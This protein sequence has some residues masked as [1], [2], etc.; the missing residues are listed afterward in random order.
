MFRT[1]IHA[2]H[3][4]VLALLLVG[5]S[6]VMAR[7]QTCVPDTTPDWIASV[8]MASSSAQVRP[9]DCATVEQTPPDFSWPDLSADAQYQVTLT[10][11]DGHSKTLA[12]PQNWINWDEILPAGAY[13]WQVQATNASGTQTSRVRRFVV[14]AAA[15]PFL[16]PDWTV[17]FD[18][19]A[20][21]PH[22]RSLP[23]A[24]TWQTMINQRQAEFGLLVSRVDSKLADPVQAEPTSAVRAAITAQTH[25]EC[26]RML[27]AALAWIVTGRE[28]HWND[29][30][31]RALNLAA[32][33]P[34]GTT[35]YANADEAAR[36]VAWTLALAYDSLHARLDANQKSLL[37]AP[38]L[39]R[40]SDMYGD[41]IGTR[42]RVAV[43][44]YDSHGNHTLTFLA[45]IT[46]LL[47]GDLPEAY[48][49]LRDTLPLALSWI[50]PWGGED[51]GFGNG[52]A[53]AQWITGDFL[54]PWSILRWTLGI[55]VAQ[56][57]WVRNYARY[58]AYF[59]P[60]G[61]PVGAFGD[62]AELDLRETWGSIGRA[63][64]LFAPGPLARWYA[65]Q[66][67]DGDPTR[68][69]VLLAPPDVPGP[70]TFPEGTPD[71]ALLSS[72]G[73][74]AM[75]SSLAD[76][77]RI[78]IYFKSSLYGSYN[79][80]HADQ[81]SFV[82]NAGGR[83]LAID[84]GHY[85]DYDTPHWRQWY[86]Q[87]RAHNAVTYDGGQGQAVF[88]ETGL[89]GQGVITDYRQ[90]P[91]YDIV[92]GDATLA[93]GGALKEARRSLVYLRPNLAVVYDRLASD[94]PRR[95]EWNIHALN[96]MTVASERRIS[97]HNDPQSLCVDMLAGPAV[98]FAQTDLFTADPLNGKPRQ[99]HGSFQSVEPLASA[100]FV[101][102]LNVGC[103]P[104]AAGAS[105]ANGVWSVTV[106][107]RLVSIA[108]D[109]SISVGASDTTPP[110]VS[111]TSP[112]PGAVVS[113]TIP[114]TA[115]ASDNVGVVGVQF[116]YDGI[117][118]D[119]EDA[120]VPYSAT[121]YTNNVPNGSYTFTAVAR[122]AAGNTATSAPVTI[123][124][125]NP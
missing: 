30:L 84:S 68:L 8:P 63:Y 11:P 77:A 33:D 121:A 83:A 27:E 24:T 10:Y 64:S 42:A 110:A 71:G 101:A 92:T 31:R 123:T 93:Y 18:A 76:P 113:G 38:M 22:P 89:L 114:V 23:D 91:D 37:L 106:G 59:L 53:Y 94:M 7:A 97:I 116:R 70:A 49:G 3:Q 14:S 16:V 85:D 66:V 111:I 88:E 15:V 96:A 119:A 108:A 45:L 72:I 69:E 90:R 20:N 55:D 95:W 46:V 80:S 104:V 35:S 65:S 54:V 75:H 9:P 40:A 48:A 29:A 58:L 78:S 19:A 109:G 21:R 26:R 115:T 100:E 103:V 1:S 41:I 4:L 44:P 28:E 81:L 57:A 67:T 43:H 34:R 99:W 102:L 118:F 39:V 5:G 52:T 6:P 2:I 117:P 79:H 107:A 56:K 125:S 87:T 112:A 98:Q 50:S 120:T 124:V 13:S 47:A 61:T 73:W 51:G 60:P 86:K 32:W 25:D 82:V 36:T 122:D 74:A 17:L 62:G 12:A 105:K